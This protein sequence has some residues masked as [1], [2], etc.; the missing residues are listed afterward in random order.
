MTPSPGEPAALFGRARGHESAAINVQKS[1][2]ATSATSVKT[3]WMIAREP[4]VS[5]ITQ[6]LRLDR[7]EGVKAIDVRRR[8]PTLEGDDLP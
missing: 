5:N 1:G 7:L 8:D 4:V 3:G 2:S 6:W